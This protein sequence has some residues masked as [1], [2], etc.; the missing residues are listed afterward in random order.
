[1][2][3]RP[4]EMSA[5]VSRSQDVSAIRQNE[6]TKQDVDYGNN[7]LHMEKRTEQIAHTVVQKENAEQQNQKFDAREKGSNTYSG[8]GRVKKKK[9]QSPEGASKALEDSLGFDVKI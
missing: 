8:F 6:E 4:V 7:Q 3:I 1:M 9:K 2:A 5:L